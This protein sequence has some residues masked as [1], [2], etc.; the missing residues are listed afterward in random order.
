MDMRQSPS[1]AIGSG[2][3]RRTNYLDNSRHVA[4][5]GVENPHDPP[6]LMHSGAF[7]IS[8]NMATSATGHVTPIN[9]L[10]PSIMGAINGDAN[11]LPGNT[12]MDYFD[13]DLSSF[14]MDGG[15]EST[16]IALDPVPEEIDLDAV[17]MTADQ[18]QVMNPGPAIPNRV[19][20]PTWSNNQGSRQGHVADTLSQKAL[21]TGQQLSEQVS[22]KLLMILPKL[23][24]K[25]TAP[26][27]IASINSLR[28]SICNLRLS[29]RS[30]TLINSS[31]CSS[32][33]L[34]IWTRMAEAAS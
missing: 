10:P 21:V 26:F 27:L 13:F 7:L 9:E 31:D 11:Q 22:V 3:F 33:V 12:A 23:M 16:G 8:N 14:A 2:A 5:L 19:I 4:Y 34:I 28:N 30:S 1:T 32:K 6:S 17:Q 20:E 24:L 29:S 18:S 15:L 25:S